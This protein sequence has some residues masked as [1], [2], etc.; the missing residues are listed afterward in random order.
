[1][2]FFL[3]SDK[4]FRLVNHFKCRNETKFIIFEKVCNKIYDCRFG[5]DELSCTQQTFVNP[6]CEVRN[7]TEIYCTSNTSFIID[8][9]PINVKSLQIS[10][11]VRSISFRDSLLLTLL[12][13]R[14]SP[15]FIQSLKKHQLKNLVYL[16]IT[17]SFVTNQKLKFPY[18]LKLLQYLDLSKNPIKT[19]SF[20]ETFNSKNLLMLNISETE[21]SNIQSF[22]RLLNM[23]IFV[24]S[25]TSFDLSLMKNLKNLRKV[26]CKNYFVCC[27]LWQ[28]NGKDKF[29]RPSQSLFQ[30]CDQIIK[31]NLI[32][33]IVWIYGIFGFFLNFI[34]V[35][36][37]MKSVMKSKCFHFYLS[38]GDI[39]VSIYMLMLAITS[40]FYNDKIENRVFW[41]KSI[42]CQVMGTM[43]TYSILVSIVAMT[44]ITIERHQVITK[45]FSS[46]GIFN[47]SKMITL[48]TIIILLFIS[49]FPFL[50]EKVTIFI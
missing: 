34:S 50:F 42:F 29:C 19:L 5:S 2:L 45:P 46:K 32:R 17:Q 21:I 31:S 37:I 30:S 27:I 12:S 18:Q 49:I 10:G 7:F 22:K 9:V 40:L 14:E 43:L 11:D 4:H 24:F 15:L 26:I 3:F 20:L 33:I 47:Y 1:M 16:S 41:K 25:K 38:F 35:L 48:L 23:E 28:L 13:I 8:D 6:F 39:L 44:M 36:Y